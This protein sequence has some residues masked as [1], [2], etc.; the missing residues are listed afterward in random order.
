VGKRTTHS[1]IIAIFILAVEAFFGGIYVQFAARLGAADTASVD[2]HH[3]VVCE[4]GH[5]SGLE[6]GV[7]EGG[8]TG[9]LGKREP[10]KQIVWASA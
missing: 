8:V 10:A 3:G 7:A 9:V 5:G 4:E 2:V 6:G 1:S